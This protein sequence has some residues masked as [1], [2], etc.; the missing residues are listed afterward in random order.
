MKEDGGLWARRAAPRDQAL[1]ASSLQL[2]FHVDAGGQVEFHQRIDGLVGGIH[3]VHQTQV[4]TDFQLVTRRLVD[5]RRTQHIE[6]LDAGWQRHRAV[7]DCA[8]ALGRINDLSG[9]L[10]DLLVVERFQTDTD[11]L[12][13]H[14]DSL[15]SE[16]RAADALLCLRWDGT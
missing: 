5:V 3:D 13:C 4:R 16:E 7:N 10:V 11:F 8:G 12:V 1:H 14:D 9:G 2:D 15:K 6:T